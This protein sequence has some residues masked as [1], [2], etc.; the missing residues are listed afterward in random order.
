M[1]SGSYAGE[2]SASPV[3]RDPSLDLLLISSSV[4]QRHINVGQINHVPMEAHLETCCMLGVGKFGNCF[5]LLRYHF[6]HL[7][8]ADGH[9]E[10]LQL[11]LSSRR[12]QALDAHSALLFLCSFLALPGWHR[13]TPSHLTGPSTSTRNDDPALLCVSQAPAASQRC[14][15]WS[16]LLLSHHGHLPLDALVEWRCLPGALLLLRWAAGCLGALPTRS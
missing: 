15:T 6:E 12:G 5:S 1:W 3:E 2:T 10:V 8:G 4:N 7:Y 14:S 13:M 11:K 16:R 9:E